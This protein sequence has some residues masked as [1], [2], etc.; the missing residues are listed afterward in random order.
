MLPSSRH[1]GLCLILTK[2]RSSS[3]NFID[4]EENDHVLLQRI[5]PLNMADSTPYTASASQQKTQQSNTQQVASDGEVCHASLSAFEE[6]R[7]H[8]THRAS[9]F[10]PFR[11][12]RT[13]RTMIPGARASLNLRLS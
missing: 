5:T 11:C 10:M 1:R 12:T 8:H 9:V 4:V 2:L 13:S 7:E 3:L 6:N